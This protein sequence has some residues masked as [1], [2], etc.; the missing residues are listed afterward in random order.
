MHPKMIAKTVGTGANSKSAPVP[1]IPILRVEL[2][3]M[4]SAVHTLR[5]SKPVIEVRQWLLRVSSSPL[6]RQHQRQSHY[7]QTYAASL[8][9]G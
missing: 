1:K 6:P 3:A 2:K 4:A 5:A 8:L 9:S 7:G